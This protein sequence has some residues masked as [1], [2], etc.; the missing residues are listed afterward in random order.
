MYMPSKHINNIC[1]DCHPRDYVKTPSVYS[2]ELGL[3]SDCGEMVNEYLYKCCECGAKAWVDEQWVNNNKIEGDGNEMTTTFEHAIRLLRIDI[4]RE[5]A[6]A[7]HS[8]ENKQ[9]AL[10]RK[11]IRLEILR[12]ELAA[13]KKFSN[14][15]ICGH[16]NHET[17]PVGGNE[18][19]TVCRDCGNEL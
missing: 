14:V 18:T 16:D 3:Y 2:G 11:A 4:K 10:N 5:E 19:I 1:M 15:D 7:I 12:Q 8:Y 9:D 6:R 17:I 13:L